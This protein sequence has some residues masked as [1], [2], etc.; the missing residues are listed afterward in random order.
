MNQYQTNQKI[1]FYFQE[2]QNQCFTLIT[3]LIYIFFDYNIRKI[4]DFFT[5]LLYKFLIKNN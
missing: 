3:F 5:N 4:N 2:I 1:L